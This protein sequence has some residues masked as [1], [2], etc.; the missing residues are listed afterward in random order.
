MVRKTLHIYLTGRAWVEILKPVKFF[1]P[2]ARPEMPK[3]GP[4]PS[5]A[6]KLR[7]DAP[8]RMVMGRN[9]SAR[10][11]RI[12]FEPSPN[13][14]RPEKCSGLCTHHNQTN[15]HLWAN[16]L[17]FSSSTLLHLLFGDFAIEVFPCLQLCSSSSSGCIDRPPASL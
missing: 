8:G 10:N 2:R 1:L 4:G 16:L 9:F 7:P 11:N 14:T 17:Q 5:P 13:P 15:L 12:F 6:R 3:P